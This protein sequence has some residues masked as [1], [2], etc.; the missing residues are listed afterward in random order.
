MRATCRQ[1]ELTS[2]PPGGTFMRD[3]A[4][5][6]L[7]AGVRCLWTALRTELARPGIRRNSYHTGLSAMDEN[8]RVP[9]QGYSRI[10]EVVGPGAAVDPDGANPGRAS[11]RALVSDVR[12]VSRKR[13][14]L[15]R[16]LRFARRTGRERVA[17]G[18]RGGA[19]ARAGR[20]RVAGRRRPPSPHRGPYRSYGSRAC[21]TRPYTMRLGRVL[22]K[23]VAEAE[24][25]AIRGGCLSGTS[26][27][28]NRAGR[29]RSLLERTG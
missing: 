3:P 10:C 5:H 16:S 4:V 7:V 8:R 13:A 26:T 29:A 27:A 1:L 14:R 23:M 15:G 28:A 2:A 6:G 18:S 12:Y 17:P 25:V 19:V 21:P 24:A 22:S 9:S 11:C 20:P